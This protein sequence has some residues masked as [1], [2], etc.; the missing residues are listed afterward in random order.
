LDYSD[1]LDLN[2]LPEGDMLEGHFEARYI[3]GD[4]FVKVAAFPKEQE[5]GILAYGPRVD[6]AMAEL[7]HNGIEK[8]RALDVWWVELELKK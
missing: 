3:R 1:L 2:R 6:E 5:D 7:R 8:V 4:E